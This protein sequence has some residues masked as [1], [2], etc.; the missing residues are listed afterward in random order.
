MFECKGEEEM[1][2]ET[3]NVFLFPR[4]IGSESRT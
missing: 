1:V 2:A 3:K 4:K